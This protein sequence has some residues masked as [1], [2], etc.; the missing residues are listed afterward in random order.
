M[1]RYRLGALRI[2][3]EIH[4]EIKTVRIKTIESRG[5]AYK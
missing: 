3:Y 4:E 1:Y 2:L 5:S